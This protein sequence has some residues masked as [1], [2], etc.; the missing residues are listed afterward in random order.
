MKLVFVDENSGFN[1]RLI[2]YVTDL[3]SINNYT[4]IEFHN[5]CH[6]IN[7]YFSL[8]LQEC[9]SMIYVKILCIS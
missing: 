8:V 6:N 7:K 4:H 5:F 9:T 1:A 2:T 3:I